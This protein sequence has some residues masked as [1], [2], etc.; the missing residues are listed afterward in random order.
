M[1]TPYIFSRTSLE[2][3]IAD[4]IDMYN[5]DRADGFGHDRTVS[6]TTSEI[7]DS[8]DGGIEQSSEPAPL[9]WCQVLAENGPIH[10]VLCP[11]CLQIAVNAALVI[12]ASIPAYVF[13][14][15]RCGAPA[16]DD[17]LDY[18]ELPNAPGKDDPDYGPSNE[19]L[20]CDDHAAAHRTKWL[21]DTLDTYCPGCD[22]DLTTARCTCAAAEVAV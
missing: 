5:T 17:P 14:C 21:L 13:R 3:L 15:A 4:A 16:T 19:L 20:L 1:T 8:F 10:L 11:R 7:L 6:M 12:A 22:T 18:D 2:Q 9:R